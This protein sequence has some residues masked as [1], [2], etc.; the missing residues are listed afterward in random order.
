MTAI[1][2]TDKQVLQLVLF[3]QTIPVL[4]ED[5]TISPD[6]ELPISDKNSDIT[7]YAVEKRF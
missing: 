1:A 7:F 5:I 3:Y 2:T 6:Q 4:N